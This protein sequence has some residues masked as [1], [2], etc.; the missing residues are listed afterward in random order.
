[1]VDYYSLDGFSPRV[2][3]GY[4]VRRINKLGIA[5]VEAAFDGC[6][7]SFTQ[8]VVLALVSTEV[9]TT[10]TELSRNM[11]HDKGALTRVVDQLEERGLVARRRDEEDRRVSKLSA[12]DAG[13][14]IVSDLAT[15]VIEV[16]NTVLRDFDHQEVGRLIDML[17]RLLDRLELADADAER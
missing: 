10:C 2:S 1:M 4:L 8:W 16:W 7:I 14:A 17:T 5:R 6:D 9:A 12:T 11:D 15:R 13:Q 3:L